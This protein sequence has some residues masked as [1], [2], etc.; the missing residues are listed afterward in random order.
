ME[1][2]DSIT[3]GQLAKV[4]TPLALSYFKAEG[5]YPIY[6]IKAS[7][8]LTP[9]RLDLGIKIRYCRDYFEGKKS[10]LTYDLYAMH[11]AVWNGFFESDPPKLGQADYMAAFEAMIQHPEE[12][13]DPSILLPIDR[14]CTLIDGAHR[15]SIAAHFGLDVRVVRS[16]SKG[17]TYDSLHFEELCRRRAPQFA[18]YIIQQMAYSY[19]DVQQSSRVVGI[20]SSM[21][22]EEREKMDRILADRRKLIYKHSTNLSAEQFDLVML[23]MHKG[24]E[25]CG[26]VHT[27]NHVT[28]PLDRSESTLY[29]IDEFTQEQSSL[30]VNELRSL[31]L[32]PKSGLYVSGSHE[33]TMAI[34]EAL[35]NSGPSPSLVTADSALPNQMDLNQ[36]AQTALVDIIQEYQKS[37]ALQQSTIQSWFVPELARLERLMAENAESLEWHRQEKARLHEQITR[38][39]SMLQAKQRSIFKILRDRLGGYFQ[40]ALHSKIDTDAYRIPVSLDELPQQG[41]R[42]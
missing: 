41:G 38:L 11:I 1:T 5:T 16:E 23:H 15:L 20:M 40:S 31:L 4:L 14:D 21:R 32:K 13:E 2:V 27:S 34:A 29:F 12:L 18:D 19:C 22:A 36:I 39:Q 42:D 6:R 10:S 30:L 3:H 17:H 24:G 37:V 25:L 8:L 7:Q 28:T 33:A 26:N 9:A 35:L